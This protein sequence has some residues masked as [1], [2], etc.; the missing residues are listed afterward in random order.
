MLEQFHHQARRS[1]R[2][3]YYCHIL[4]M[5]DISV[6]LNPIKPTQRC[7]LSQNIATFLI[8]KL[9]S[10]CYKKN[11]LTLYHIFRRLFWKIHF[12]I[13]KNIFLYCERYFLL[14]LFLKKKNL[15]SKYSLRYF[16]LQKIDI[17]FSLCKVNTT[18]L[19]S[20]PSFTF[21]FD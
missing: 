16:L 21:S 6:L 14:F 2:Y 9:R 18:Q 20:L 10:F 15:D 4:I 7:T 1:M 17:I 3:K 13:S 8:F 5:I 11:F 19:P 12:L